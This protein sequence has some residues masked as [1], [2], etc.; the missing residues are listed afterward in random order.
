MEK[1][2]EAANFKS[3]YML[4]NLALVRKR[5]ADLCEF[6]ASLGYRA[7]SRTGFLATKKLCLEKRTNKKKSGYPVM[8]Q[9]GILLNYLLHGI[10][11][12]TM[13]NLLQRISAGAGLSQQPTLDPAGANHL[14]G[15][16]PPL[17][18]AQASNLHLS[19]LKSTTSMGPGLNH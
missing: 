1:D 13:Q 15:I 18:Q 19:R 6:E 5:Q 10:G 3:R 16:R 2:N 14:N 4:L 12:R 11:K 8:L 7:T 17:K 9:W